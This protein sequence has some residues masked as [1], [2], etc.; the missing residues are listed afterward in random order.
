MRRI[1]FELDTLLEID[2]IKGHLIRTI[3]QSQIGDHSVQ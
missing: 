1:S 3:A 2:Q